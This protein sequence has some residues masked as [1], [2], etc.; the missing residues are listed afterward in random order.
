VETAWLK[1]LGIDT[2][3]LAIDDGSGL[4]TYDRI[5][6]HDLV[7]VLKHDWDGPNRDVVLDALP[8]AGV[9]G[10]LKSAFAGT[11]AERH[12]FAKTGSLSHVS[13]LAG[14]AAN[15]KHGAVIFAFQVDDWVGQSAALRELRARVLAHFVED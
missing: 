12:V 13:T 10:T 11:A 4:S 8:I 2:A 3:A 9:R 7:T 14:Y 1:G 15:K 5:T 6:P